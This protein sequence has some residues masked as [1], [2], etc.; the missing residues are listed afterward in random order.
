DAE[1]VARDLGIEYDVIDI[2]PIYDAFVEAFPDDIERV[3]HVGELESVDEEPPVESVVTGIDLD[4][5]LVG[6][7]FGNRVSDIEAA[8]AEGDYEVVD[9]RLHVADAELDAAMFEVEEERQYAGDGEMVE[10]GETVVIV[11]N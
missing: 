10:A 11:R 3:M 1:R 6:P 8:I 4:Y 9:G 2:G 5:S 7:E